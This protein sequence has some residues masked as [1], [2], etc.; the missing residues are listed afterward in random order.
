MEAVAWLGWQR[1]TP[2][3]IE[4]TIEEVAQGYALKPCFE[5]EGTGQ[6]AYGPPG[7]E[8]PCVVCKGTGKNYINV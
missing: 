7:T 5:C 4:I 1:E 3:E 2:V 8:G 6:W